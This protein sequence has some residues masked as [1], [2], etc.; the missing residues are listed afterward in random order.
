M[1]DRS[2][3]HLVPGQPGVLHAEERVVQVPGGCK[4]G[5]D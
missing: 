4:V 1:E 3:Q 5:G 2:R